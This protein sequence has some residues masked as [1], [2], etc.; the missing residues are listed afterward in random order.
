MMKER[1]VII[2]SSKR[3]Q[4]LART[5]VPAFALPVVRS[6]VRRESERRLAKFQLTFGKDVAENAPTSV[7]R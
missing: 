6:Y 5:Y 2:G 1:L 3:G 7:K 4:V